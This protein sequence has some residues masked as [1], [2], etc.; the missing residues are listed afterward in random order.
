MTAV[1]MKLEDALRFNG[2][3]IEQTDVAASTLAVAGG[4]IILPAM[5]LSSLVW[6][7]ATGTDTPG[8]S[9]YLRDMPIFNDGYRPYILSAILDRYMTRRLSYDMPGAFGLAMRRHLNLIFGPMSE[10]NRRYLSTAV[11]LPLTTQDATVESVATD[12]TR[13]AQSDFPQGQ[14]AGNV[15]YASS[16][17][18]R[19][20]SGD[21][22]TT[23]EGRMEKS[24][25]ELLQEQRATFINVDEEVLDAISPLFLSVFD[26][27]EWDS[28]LGSGFGFGFAP[29]GII[30]NHW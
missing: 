13:D 12:K 28:E 19:V 11:A 14:L 9:F 7:R 6:Q 18:D 20:S 5:Q 15:D 4:S 26:R 3:T 10:L 2:Y 30:V 25:M 29:N 17:V 27:D 24:V 16:A 1:P 21:T 23:Y 22:L 8:D